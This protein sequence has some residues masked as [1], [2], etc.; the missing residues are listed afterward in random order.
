MVKIQLIMENLLWFGIVDPKEWG[1]NM[2][3]AISQD[4]I[5][6]RRADRNNDS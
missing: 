5:S 3:L 6:G 4:E 2:I 1:L